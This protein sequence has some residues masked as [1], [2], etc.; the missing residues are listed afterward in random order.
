[1]SYCNKKMRIFINA[2]MTFWLYALYIPYVYTFNKWVSLPYF[3]R[4]KSGNIKDNVI[5]VCKWK[6]FRARFSDKFDLLC[7]SA[8]EVLE[9]V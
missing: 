8:S 3:W 4:N 9:S 7:M 6:A 2:F 5:F 1:M